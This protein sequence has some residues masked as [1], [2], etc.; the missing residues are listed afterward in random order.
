MGKPGGVSVTDLAGLGQGPFHPHTYEPNWYFP[1]TRDLIELASRVPKQT[2]P[3]V[4][5]GPNCLTSSCSALPRSEQNP[6]QSE[7]FGCGER[8]T[9]TTFPK[10]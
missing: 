1:H 10:A 8:A 5:G 9:P 2:K 3:R 6:G 4:L 7:L